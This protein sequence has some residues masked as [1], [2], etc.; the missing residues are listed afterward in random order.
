MSSCIDAAEEAMSRRTLPG[1]TSGFR[2]IDNQT[3]GFH[4]GELWVICGRPGMGKTALAWACTRAVAGQGIPVGFNE[5][6]MAEKQMGQRALA[7]EAA[8]NLRSLRMGDFGQDTID[9]LVKAAGDLSDL[10]VDLYTPSTLSPTQIRFRARSLAIRHQFIYGL[11]IADHL[12]LMNP[13]RRI[14]SREQQISTISREM[15]QLAKDLNCPV[16][17][18]AQLNRKLED[19][20]DKRPRLSDLRESGAIEQ[21]ADGVIGL[22]QPFPYTGNDEDRG[23]AEAIIL[24]QRN[25]P[26]GTVELEWTPATASYWSKSRGSYPNA[27]QF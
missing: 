8:L 15:K 20:P 1:L 24:K 4:P 26:V 3:T 11:V 21:D 7:R 18:L 10:P 27:E 16:I 14:D 12:G 23:K 25:G 17:L 9:K 2:E 6:E 22:Y 13:G 19:R 5:I